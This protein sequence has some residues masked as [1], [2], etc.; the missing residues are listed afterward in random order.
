MNEKNPL[1]SSAGLGLLAL[2]GI[3]AHAGFSQP[4]FPAASKNSAAA[5]LTAGRDLQHLAAPV[6]ATSFVSAA[7][8]PLRPCPPGIGGLS[9]DSAAESLDCPLGSSGVH[10]QGDLVAALI[11][12]KYLAFQESLRTP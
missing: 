7:S 8:A 4:A 3:F 2:F 11:L 9:S 5:E 10:R 12:E 6:P 1:R